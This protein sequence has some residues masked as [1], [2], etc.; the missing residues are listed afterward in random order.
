MI[1]FYCMGSL[2]VLMEW[3]ANGTKES[4]EF[5]VSVVHKLILKQYWNIS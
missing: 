5:M 3:L 2:H 1:S 4:P